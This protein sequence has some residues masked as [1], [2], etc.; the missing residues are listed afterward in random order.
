MELAVLK[1]VTSAFVKEL[2]AAASGKKTSL[3]FIKH[4][5]ALNPSV[6]ENEPFQVIRIGGSIYQKARLVRVKGAFRILSR[7][8][9][10]LPV[11]TSKKIFLSF[12]ENVLDPGVS[13][14][15]LNFA[16]PMKPVTRKGLLDGILLRGTKEHTFSGLMEKSIG[17]TIEKYIAD[18]R[19][20][21]IRVSVANDTV[22]LLLS[23]LTKFPWNT[24]VAGV[25][26]TGINFATFLNKHSLVNLESAQFDKLAQTKEG[27]IIDKGSAKPGFAR[28]EKETAGGYLYQ[29]FNLKV[30]ELGIK[31]KLVDT[32][33]TLDALAHGDSPIISTISRE[34][35]ERSAALIA[36]QVAGLTLF[37]KRDMT[38]IIEGSLFWRG[39][40]YKDNVAYF[41]RLLAPNYQVSFVFIDNSGILGA[42]K[43]VA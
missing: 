31:Q 28:F 2:R 17:E 3:S 38:F 42:A 34:I 19:G 35:L 22:C 18:K 27:K 10:K 41:S 21:K 8:Q 40:H 9:K 1:K 13:T 4:R 25:I 16:Y 37:H 30:K 33:K 29:H 23:G 5:L 20:V 26:G 7:E 11:F 36:C 39:W 43:L 12:I 6:K 32:T 14:V 24:L 15:A